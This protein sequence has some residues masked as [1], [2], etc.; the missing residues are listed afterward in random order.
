MSHYNGPP[1]YCSACGGDHRPHAT[2]YPDRI[3]RVGSGWRAADGAPAP[4]GM[5]CIRHA[6]EDAGLYWFSPATLRFFRSRVSAA[7]YQG[8]GGIY[9]VTSEQGPN[10]SREYSVRRFDPAIG[11][12]DTHGEFQAYATAAQAHGAA[13]RAAAGPRPLTRAQTLAVAKRMAKVPE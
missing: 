1:D 8:T 12:V 10:M 5:D 2:R 11:G 3:E 13:K 4:W 9:F 6:N 7:V